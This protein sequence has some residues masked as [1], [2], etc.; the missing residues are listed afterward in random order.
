MNEKYSLPYIQTIVYIYIYVLQIT[1]SLTKSPRKSLEMHLE[2]LFGS[3]AHVDGMNGGYTGVGAHLDASRVSHTD[4]T[5]RCKERTFG[6]LDM[7]YLKIEKNVGRGAS[8]RQAWP[9]LRQ[10]ITGAGLQL[11]PSSSII[12]FFTLRV[13]VCSQL[14]RRTQVGKAS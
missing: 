7:L 2:N 14:A 9:S 13:C 3:V 10:Y 5:C 1:I 12:R 8:L 4:T 11:F 6:K